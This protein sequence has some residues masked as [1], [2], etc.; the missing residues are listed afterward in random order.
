MF[1]VE[2]LDFFEQLFKKRPEYLRFEASVKKS[3]HF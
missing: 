1:H 3:Q 2:N